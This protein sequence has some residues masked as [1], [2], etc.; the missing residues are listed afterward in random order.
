MKDPTKKW[1]EYAEYPV[2]GVLPDFEPDMQTC[3]QCVAVAERVRD[4]IASL[5]S[6]GG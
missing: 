1:L 4:S 2:G 3:V 6:K 5:L